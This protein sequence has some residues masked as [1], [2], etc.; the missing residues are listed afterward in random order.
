MRDKNLNFIQFKQQVEDFLRKKV[1]LPRTLRTAVID[2]PTFLEEYYFCYPRSFKEVLGLSTV[3]WYYPENLKWR[4]LLDL[5]EKNFSQLNEKQRIQIQIFL[6]SKEDM[7]KFLYETKRYTSHEV[8]GNILGTAVKVSRN[9]PCHRKSTLVIETKRKRGYDDKG[10][11]RP[12]EKWLPDFDFSLTELQLKKEKRSD[13]QQRS[14]DH[15][16][17]YFENI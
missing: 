1:Y 14:I 11:L 17:K 15:I 13:L 2:T 3:L 7:L 4:I 10:S 8:F 5:Q 6:N 12:K 9:L 16:L